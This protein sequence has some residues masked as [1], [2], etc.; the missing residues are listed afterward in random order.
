VDNSQKDVY[1]DQFILTGNYP[2][3]FN[4]TTTIIYQLPKVSDVKIK[5]FDML[6]REVANL[7][8]VKQKAGMYSVRFDATIFPSG[9][10]L[11]RL[12]AGNYSETIK[13]ILTK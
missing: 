13:M 6:G 2:N 10:Y 8:N 1:P 4:P 5:V 7:L 9:V 11:C 3:P 12:T